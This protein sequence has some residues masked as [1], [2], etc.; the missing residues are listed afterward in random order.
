MNTDES[1][2]KKSS[3]GTLIRVYLRSAMFLVFEMCLELVSIIKNKIGTQMT[4]D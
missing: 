3:A 4:S 2:P 1:E